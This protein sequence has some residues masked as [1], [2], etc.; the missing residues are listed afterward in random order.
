MP[1]WVSGKIRP[2]AQLCSCCR[3]KWRIT[4]GYFWTV[5]LL[6]WNVTNIKAAFLSSF[7][8]KC[9]FKVTHF[10]SLTLSWRFHTRSH[11]SQSGHICRLW[12]KKCSVKLT[13]GDV[14]SVNITVGTKMSVTNYSF[15]HDYY[16][17]WTF[18]FSQSSQTRTTLHLPNRFTA[19]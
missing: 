13:S 5:H 6:G 1:L 14:D 2:S 8:Q 9:Y 10:P 12:H 4:Q 15:Y 7:I 16:L 17:D 18:F 11:Y 3:M 19:P